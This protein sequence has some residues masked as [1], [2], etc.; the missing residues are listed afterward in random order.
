MVSFASHWG[1]RHKPD[2]SCG[3]NT[4]AAG[5]LTA[6]AIN[7]LHR[8][9]WSYAACRPV[10][11]ALTAAIN[12]AVENCNQHDDAK[13]II[14]SLSLSYSAVTVTVT[15]QGE[16]LPV[17]E[18][19]KIQPNLDGDELEVIAALA[20]RKPEFTDD[21]HTISFTISRHR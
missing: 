21:G 9:N 10:A 1:R 3:A 4:A 19:V 7:Y 2:W 13:Q 12:Y 14:A 6:E 16:P 15:S 18:E 20:K 11:Q 8:R 17:L 5:C